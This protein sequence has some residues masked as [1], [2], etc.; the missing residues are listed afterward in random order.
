MRALFKAFVY[1]GIIIVAVLPLFHQ[2]G[3]FTIP[4][5]SPQVLGWLNLVGW[6]LILAFFFAHED[7]HRS[8][9]KTA[10]ELGI[11]TRFKSLERLLAHL[12]R[13]V[14]RK[15][16]AFSVNLVE[17]RI[18]SKEE[19]SR[20]LERIVATAYNLLQAES[21]EL[22]LFDRESGLYHSSFVLGKPFSRSAQAMLSG[23]VEGD[24]MRPQPEVLIQPIAFAGRVH[25][26]LRV[27]LKRG[28]LPSSS[29]QEIVRLLAIQGSLAIINA[30]YTEQLLKM[31]SASEETVRAKTGFLANL[32]HE[33]RG[34]L[35]IMLNAVELVLDGLCGPVN[36]DQLETLQMV[37][38]NGSHLLEL[39]N[40]VL[41]YA[42][43]ESGRI[44]PHPTEVLLGDLLVDISNVVRSQADAKGHK[45][46]LKKSDEVCAISC[47]RRH[48][49]QMLINLLTNAIKYT[50]DGGTITLWVERAPGNKIKINVKDTGV[51]IERADRHRVF[52]A[53]ERIEHSY[54]INQ[55]G[56]G[57]GMPLTKRLAEVNSGTIDFSSKPGEGS[58]FWL[59]F[60][61]ID[62]DPSMQ[63]SEESESTVEH[64]RGNREV[65][66]LAEKDD[67]ERSM[68]ARY[69]TH[70]GFRICEARSKAEAMN[71]LRN[72]SVD[73]AIL[74]NAV[75]DNQDD[76]LVSAIRESGKNASLPVILVSSR[77]FVFDI[78]KYLK[79]GVDR[80][81]IK[82]IELRKLGVIAR[83]LIDGT[84]EGAVVD[85][86]DLDLVKSKR[87]KKK[88][89]Q[90]TRVMSVDDILH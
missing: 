25:G 62:Y 7:L 70:I 66:L 76:D 86:S 90:T 56:T 11:D 27:G 60:P 22:A 57:L 3:T 46:E 39:I 50:P 65:I 17:R 36:D 35:G 85:E 72:E 4:F 75:A 78:E 59:L 73:L 12:I 58:H 49:R 16:R 52:S 9:K 43:V 10:R 45:L 1:F 89:L 40:D 5:L 47:D 15:N 55:M 48:L 51:G 8:I 80:C 53:F 38:S 81:L 63:V 67:G 23:A 2:M 61:A 20:T 28:S 54:S 64:A 87:E 30:Q 84:F 33:L 88:P 69:L 74:D 79:S 34:P 71:L 41:D 42:K 82:P 44:T 77:A 13:E 32:S 24:E 37:K 83:E 26:S 19:L 14:D 21:S 68:I 6:S 29:D 31:T 18:T